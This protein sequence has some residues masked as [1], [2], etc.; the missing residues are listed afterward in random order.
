MGKQ[1]STGFLPNT[2]TILQIVI[3][4]FKMK[5]ELGI[6]SDSRQPYNDFFSMKPY[7]LPRKHLSSATAEQL[8]CA[9]QL[10][11][12]KA[13]AHPLLGHSQSLSTVL[14]ERSHVL[15]AACQKSLPNSA[16]S[17]VLLKAPLCGSE[18]HYATRCLSSICLHRRKK[19]T[20]HYIFQFH[21]YWTHLFNTTHDIWK[22]KFYTAQTH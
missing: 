13:R 22:G 10:Q 21:R 2:V 7:I 15:T 6:S 19:S 11:W 20:F 14:Q 12:W 17:P 1:Q 3:M 8:Q 5:A 9:A 18:V 16:G 4:P